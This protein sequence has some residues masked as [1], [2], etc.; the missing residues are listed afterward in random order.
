MS[1]GKLKR[2]ADNKLRDNVLEPGKPVYE[3]IK[4]NWH[5]D[6]FKNDNPISLELACGRGEYTVG[7]ARL[8]DNGNF[9]GVDL[10]GDRIWKGSGWAID[11][12]L[13][14]VAFLRT[15]ILLLEK[16]FEAGEVDEIWITFPDPRPKL[17]DE[18]RRL[19]SPR[20]IDIYKNILR[21]EGWVRL[22]TDN[23]D[24]FEYSLEVLQSREDVVLHA[25]TFDLYQSSMEHE[26]FDIQTR[27]E[28]KHTAMGETIKYLKFQFK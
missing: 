3:K 14:H 21:K 8:F 2:F 23:T 1:R 28:R 20:F 22:K 9:I 13:N 17:R 18:K 27:Y 19:T 4:G 6:Y 15:E 7:M 16:F 24:L 5:N 11:E 25:H 26:C 12:K 10:K